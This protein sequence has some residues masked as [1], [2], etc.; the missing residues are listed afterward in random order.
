MLSGL[1][2]AGGKMDLSC[3]DGIFTLSGETPFP[4]GMRFIFPDHFRVES[5]QLKALP[6]NRFE[7][8][9]CSNIL[10]GHIAIDRSKLF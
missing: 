9:K 4:A 3:K 8:R 7:L 1:H 5:D 10:K 2:T 6:G